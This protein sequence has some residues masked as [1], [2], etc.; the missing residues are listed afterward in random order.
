MKSIYKEFRC[1]QCGDLRYINVNGIC[2]DCNNRNTLLTLAEQRRAQ[3]KLDFSVN[4]IS[5]AI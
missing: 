4:E 3:H 5:L 1:P 2:F